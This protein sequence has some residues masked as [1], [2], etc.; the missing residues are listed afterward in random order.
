M[1]LQVLE[2]LRKAITEYNRDL[3]ISSARK[4]IEEKIDLY[5]GLD[6]MTT[7]IR[8]IGEGFSKGE[9]W[10]PDL[11]GASAAMSAALPILEEELKKEGKSR[12]SLG[13]VVIGAV[14]GDIHTIGKAMVAALLT[15]AGFRVHDLGINIRAD[16][17]VWAV[18]EHKA[19]ILAMS[20]LMTTTALEQKNTI[21]LLKK[22]GLRDRVK[23]MVGGGAITQEFADAIGADGY[24][25]TAPGAMDLA[26]R[27][28]GK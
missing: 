3:A 10:L 4:L 7:T 19:D 5:D 25:A 18:R 12:G 17:F 27:L 6:V 1:S 8:Q 22:E 28:V 23:V 20:A 13:T 11:V 24:D 2:D 14:W 21:E 15:A 16:E 26:R 9:L